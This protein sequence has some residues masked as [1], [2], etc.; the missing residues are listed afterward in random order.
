MQQKPADTLSGYKRCYEFVYVKDSLNKCVSTV[1][2]WKY[3]DI[4]RVIIGQLI[5]V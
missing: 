5:V 1:K 3:Y 2:V 4:T